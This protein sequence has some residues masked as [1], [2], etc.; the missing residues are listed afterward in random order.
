MRI[1][2]QEKLNENAGIAFLTS[3]FL[4]MIITS[5]GIR[6]Y[7][8]V[9]DMRDS[10]LFLSLFHPIIIRRCKAIAAEHADELEGLSTQSATKY[11]GKIIKEED[12]GLWDKLD[13]LK[14]D[15]PSWNARR[16]AV[17]ERNGPS[18]K[19]KLSQIKARYGE[20]TGR[21]FDRVLRENYYR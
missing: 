21:V 15:K 10:G 16:M 17:G 9:G 13:A 18:D 11:L 8:T 12:P 5:Q 14:G 2:E 3:M 4:S 6:L 19:E 7:D 20:S 1:T